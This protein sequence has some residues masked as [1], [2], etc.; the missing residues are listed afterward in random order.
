MKRL[1]FGLLIAACAGSVLALPQGGL[2]CYDPAIQV[3]CEGAC[4]QETQA[5]GCELDE[6]TGDF[7][8][9]LCQTM[10]TNCVSDCCL[11]N[12]TTCTQGEIL[13]CDDVYWDCMSEMSPWGN[14][15]YTEAECAAQ[16][17]ACIELCG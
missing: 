1:I 4:T 13:E 3:G 8:G 16:K 7:V 2:V 6:L 14:P 17:A 5:C 15:V 11:E 12:T 9:S 10:Y